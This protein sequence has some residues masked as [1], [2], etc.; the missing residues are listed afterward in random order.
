[1]NVLDKQ[2]IEQVIGGIHIKY[3]RKLPEVLKNYQFKPGISGNIKGRPKG[4]T[5]KEYAREWLFNLTEK[6]K[7][8]FMRKLDPET[9]WKMSEGMPH[10][11][12]DLTVSARPVP[13]LEG[14][15]LNKKALENKDIK[16]LENPNQ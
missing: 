3:K 2:E 10:Q 7:K 8:T 1:M 15:V 5:L 6:E 13:L 16:L 14:V 4:K 11:S 9:I 12:S